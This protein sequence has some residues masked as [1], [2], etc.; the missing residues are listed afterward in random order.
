[1]KSF[2]QFNEEWIK[3]VR[4]KL[5]LGSSTADIFLN[6]SRSELMRSMSDSGNYGVRAFLMRNGDMYL[7]ANEMHSEILYNI[8]PGGYI[9]NYKNALPIAIE[10]EKRSA[11]VTIS[12]FLKELWQNNLDPDD[13]REI[14]LSD[15]AKLIKNHTKMKKLFSSISV[16]TK[17]MYG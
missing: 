14:V 17:G 11:K 6:P 3:T 1:M 4:S 8:L 16:D 9:K 13:D 7:W 5:A 2:K 10:F 12:T 15:I